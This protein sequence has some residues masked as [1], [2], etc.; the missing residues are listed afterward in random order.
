M[1]RGF[2]RMY[3]GARRRESSGRHTLRLIC[4][5]VAL[6]AKLW[7]RSRVGLISFEIV[8]R[9]G[10]EVADFLAGTDGMDGGG[11]PLERL[12]WDHNFVVFT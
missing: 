12:E 6:S 9:G 2:K 4:S 7:P 11:R 10:D 1:T 5:K 3:S 8:D